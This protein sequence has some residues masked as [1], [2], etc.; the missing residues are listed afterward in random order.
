MARIRSVH[1][2]IWTD[3]AFVSC[4]AFARILCMA[5]W[6]EADDQGAFPW[7]P[8]TIKMRLLPADEVDVPALLAEL[9]EHNIIC[10]YEVEGRGYGLFRNFGKFQRPK[11]PNAIHHVPD[12]LRT[13]AGLV[14]HQTSTAPETDEQM[15]DG[16]GRMEVGS[17]P[18]GSALPAP[19]RPEEKPLLDF[20]GLIFG[21]FLDW[22]KASTG[23]S[24]QSLRS[25]LGKACGQCGDGT[26]LDT[27][28]RIRAGPT[29]A[30]PISAITAALKRVQNV[31]HRKAEF[32]NPFNQ[33]LAESG[34]SAAFGAGGEDPLFGS[35]RPTG[36][37]PDM[38]ST[39]DGQ[40]E[41]VAGNPG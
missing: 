16:G 33:V 29:Q 12:E 31:Q 5:L 34:G 4:S 23:R 25:Y 1:P 11:K 26:V 20:R 32:G 2:T 13:Y 24:E 41:R 27:L 40:F 6:T 17:D 18:D 15:E 38:G 22:L 9:V 39:I 28:A 14:P 21:E 7:K 10:R 3:E 37:S 36:G 30:D 19:A 35:G 8:V